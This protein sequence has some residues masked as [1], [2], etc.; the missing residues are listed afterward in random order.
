MH[1]EICSE[2]IFRK[3]SEDEKA[4]E[5]LLKLLLT[6]NACNIFESTLKIIKVMFLKKDQDFFSAQYQIMNRN[7]FLLGTKFCIN[8]VRTYKIL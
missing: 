1:T 5:I 4:L 6:V 7:Y 8:Q 3:V 2:K